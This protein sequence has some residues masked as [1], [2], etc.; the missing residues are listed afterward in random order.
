MLF[1]IRKIGKDS[2]FFVANKK[3]SENPSDRIVIMH[4]INAEKFNI[5]DLKISDFK[6]CLFDLA[7][8]YRTKNHHPNSLIKTI[9]DKGFY[10]VATNNKKFFVESGEEEEGCICWGERIFL[11]FESYV[12]DLK[13]F[14]IDITETQLYEYI[15]DNCQKEL[16][17]IDYGY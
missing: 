13:S 8:C 12:N 16:E 7:E 14:S 17:M 11:D 15:C 4:L 6:D 5:S 9:P 1:K 10:L 2:I 3:I